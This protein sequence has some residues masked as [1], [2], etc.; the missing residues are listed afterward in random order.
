MKSAEDSAGP[1]PPDE[2]VRLEI[3]QVDLSEAEEEN[4]TAAPRVVESAA[5]S[6]EPPR[7]RAA[8]PEPSPLTVSEAP[9]TVSVRPLDDVRPTDLRPPTPDAPETPV[10]QPE[11]T[12]KSA[13]P[14]PKQAHVDAPPALKRK[15]K[16]KYPEGARKRGEEGNVTLELAVDVHGIV[17]GVKVAASCGF[18][19]LERAAIDA[20]RRVSFKPA[21]RDGKPV[22]ASARLTLTFRLRE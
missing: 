22:A 11:Q 17:V 13:A 15:I 16:P 21:R 1:R 8:P 12:A 4:E 10:A 3:A 19:E 6:P 2:P 9:D 18:A 20:A 7:P 14:A 5:A